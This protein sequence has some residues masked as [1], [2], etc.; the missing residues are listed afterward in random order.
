MKNILIIGVARAGKSTLA[1]KFN[2]KIYNHIPVDY[3]PQGHLR[4]TRN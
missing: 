3:L 2:K 1:K 4:Y